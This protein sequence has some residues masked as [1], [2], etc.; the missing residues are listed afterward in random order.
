M[1]LTIFNVSSAAYYYWNKENEIAGAPA[2]E[3]SL[4][5]VQKGRAVNAIEGYMLKTHP[6][7]PP[8]S[9][10]IGDCLDLRAIGFTY[11]PQV[12]YNDTTLRY[13]DV[14]DIRVDSAG[15]YV[16][17]GDGIHS[18]GKMISSGIR[19]KRFYLDTS[20]TFLFVYY[21]NE[22]TSPDLLTLDKTGK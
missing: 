22:V 20:R 17:S 19:N 5:L 6:V 14:S 9:A 11:G 7:L 1:I 21:Q 15:M 18:E 13:Y 2:V 4:N 10:L 3:G 12:W 8:H 16:N